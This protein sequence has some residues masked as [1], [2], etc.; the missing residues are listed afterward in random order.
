MTTL[1][2]KV[3]RRYKPLAEHEHTRP[4]R[5][6]QAAARPLH[7]PTEGVLKVTAPRMT[8]TSFR[9]MPMLARL[10]RLGDRYG[11]KGCITHSLEDRHTHDKEPLIEFYTLIGDD[12]D[13]S[14]AW[15]GVKG[16]WF[17]SRYYLSTF[18]GTCE[19]SRDG[20]PVKNGLS[21]NG[22]YPEYDLDAQD[23]QKVAAWIESLDQGEGNEAA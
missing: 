12:K 21:L 1:Y 20:G 3:G 23:C 6:D 2:K 14:L 16:Y 9:G 7:P 22:G 5:A 18:M 17:V 19:Y 10:I 13:G 11:L 4:H 8:F 15:D